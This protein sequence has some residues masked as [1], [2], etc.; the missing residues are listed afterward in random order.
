M[1]VMIQIV[2]NIDYKLFKENHRETNDNKKKKICEILADDKQN[3]NYLS[4]FS[5]I[6]TTTK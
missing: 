5:S 6:T 2:I 4:N 3:A 1:K